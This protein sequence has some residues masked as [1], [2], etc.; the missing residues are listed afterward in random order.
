[1]VTVGSIH[2]GTKHNIIGDSCQLQLTVR[3]YAP[4]VRK[5]LLAAIKR[6]TLA[7]AQAYGAPEPDI[8]P[9]E[10]TLSSIVVA[11]TRRSRRYR[12]A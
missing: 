12:N 6:K 10:A 4:E 11:I 3:S 2:G 8:T 9:I 7:V 1:M 5:Q